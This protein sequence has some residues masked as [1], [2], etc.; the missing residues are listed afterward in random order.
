MIAARR[1]SSGGLF[2]YP[3]A[4]V[5]TGEAK[6]WAWRRK[7]MMLSTTWAVDGATSDKASFVEIMN[8]TGWAIELNRRNRLLEADVGVTLGAMNA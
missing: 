1:G 2:G 8:A 4:T 3:S 5:I 7:A 6:R